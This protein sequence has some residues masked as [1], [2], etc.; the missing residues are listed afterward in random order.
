MLIIEIN[1]VKWGL[2]MF[3]L[4]WWCVLETKGDRDTEEVRKYDNNSMFYVGICNK[5][6]VVA[7]Y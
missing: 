3:Q 7:K 1:I 6:V 4:K 2:I 5:R